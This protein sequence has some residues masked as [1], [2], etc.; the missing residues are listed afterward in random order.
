MSQHPFDLLMELAPH[1]IRLDCAALHLARDRYPHLNVTRYL[2]QLDELAEEVAALRP[3][4]SANLRYAALRRVLV[5]RHGLTGNHTHYYDPDN[6]HLNRVLDTGLGIPITASLVWIEVARRLKWPV[7]G[8]ALPGHFI[9]RFDDRERFILVDPFNDG[10]TLSIADCRA[11]VREHFDNALRFRRA[12]LRPV[13]KPGILARLLRNLRN[14][15]LAHN[16]L[17]RAANI[18][19]RMTIIEP[20]NGQH[21]RDLA[22]ICCRQGDVRKAY[23]H[24]QLY[25]R[26][27]PDECDSAHVRASL[28]QLQ[29]ALAALN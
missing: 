13:S 7:F 19:R 16:D 1:Q 21:L 10:Q 20:H 29:A 4:L 11:L 15:Y 14:A 9:I 3:G 27:R 17:P 6:C 26:R 2:Q 28:K 23:A 12:Q 24:L 25:L 18:L 5:D 8:V 22:V